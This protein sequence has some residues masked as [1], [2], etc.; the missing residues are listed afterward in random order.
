MLG[1]L[2]TVRLFL[3]MLCAAYIQGSVEKLLDFHGAVAEMQH[4]GLPLPAPMAAA[5]IAFELAASA[6]VVSGW[7]RWLG[8][9]ALAVFT[10]MATFL[11]NRFWELG[12]H[13]RMM[14]ENGFFE[15]IGLAGAFLLVAWQ[16][17]KGG[18]H[19]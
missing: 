9:S 5:V 11:A 19:G 18:Q 3:L 10:V 16:D 6:M 17:W 14:S 7:K 8:A 2:V 12:G 13:E 15:H 4:F 1:G